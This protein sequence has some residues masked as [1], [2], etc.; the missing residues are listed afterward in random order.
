MEVIRA[1]LI[2]LND[3]VQENCSAYWGAFTFIKLP[4][5]IQLLA[6]HYASSSNCLP[7]EKSYKIIDSMFLH[8][9]SVILISPTFVEQASQEIV[10]GFVLLMEFC[11]LL[12]NIDTKTQNNNVESLLNEMVKMSVISEADKTKIL[13]IR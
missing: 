5:I 3:A 11:P 4:H 9:F 2:N 1:S 7:G 6:C 13:E 12:N 8:F 10:D